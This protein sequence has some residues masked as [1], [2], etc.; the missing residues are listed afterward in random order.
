MHKICKCECIEKKN[1]TNICEKKYSRSCCG[2]ADE[3]LVKFSTVCD[4]LF[5]LFKT[6]SVISLKTQTCKAFSSVFLPFTVGVCFPG[7]AEEPSSSQKGVKN[8]DNQCDMKGHISSRHMIL[9]KL[10]QISPHFKLS[11]LTLTCDTYSQH[12]PIFFFIWGFLQEPNICSDGLRGFSFSFLFSPLDYW[13]FWQSK[14]AQEWSVN[15]SKNQWTEI[16]LF[17]L[18]S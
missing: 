6:T 18:T 15:Y 11:S 5:C 13:R 10:H 4:C 8:W 14:S 1:K 12:S 16:E 9:N 7:S 3:N 17:K 2:C